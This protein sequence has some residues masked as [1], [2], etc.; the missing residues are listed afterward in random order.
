[1]IRMERKIRKSDGLVVY[2]FEVDLRLSNKRSKIPI[3]DNYDN[4]VG[5]VRIGELGDPKV[6]LR[7]I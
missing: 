1:M 3:Y 4:R 2:V 5:Y 7:G 6:S